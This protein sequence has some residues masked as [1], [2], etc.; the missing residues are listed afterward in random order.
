MK[1]LRIEDIDNIIISAIEDTDTEDGM[2]PQSVVWN[3]IYIA[4]NHLRK[5]ATEDENQESQ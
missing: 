4:L 3:K 2:G 5:I 1:L